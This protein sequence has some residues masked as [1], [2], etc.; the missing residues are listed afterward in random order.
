MAEDMVPY[1]IVEVIV[2]D[3]RAGPHCVV[4]VVVM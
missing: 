2:G 1:L 3:V 4:K